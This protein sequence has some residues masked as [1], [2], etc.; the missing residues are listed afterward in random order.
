MPRVF[1]KAFSVPRSFGSGRSRKK[2]PE[3]EKSINL[4]VH[5][6]N[7]HTHDIGMVLLANYFSN[8]LSHTHASLK[9]P[10]LILCL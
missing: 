8:R 1:A 10:A 5:R 2:K 9:R 7:T 3:S 6:S 4:I